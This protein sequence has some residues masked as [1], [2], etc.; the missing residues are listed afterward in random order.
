[1]TTPGVSSWP[2]K[3][4]K[5]S[6]E[7]IKGT[8]EGSVRYTP[9]P[10]WGSSLPRGELGISELGISEHRIGEYGLGERGIE[11]TED[12]AGVESDTCEI[13]MEFHNDEVFQMR[14]RFHKKQFLIL[15]C[16]LSWRI[17]PRRTEDCHYHRSRTG[18][19]RFCQ[20]GKNQH[21]AKTGNNRHG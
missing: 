13:P 17:C 20:S 9:G 16:L 18:L 7:D 8:W 14:F 1:M 10:R 2:Y 4:G 3:E 5:A 21:L 15:C 11:E 19:G 12:F 6:R